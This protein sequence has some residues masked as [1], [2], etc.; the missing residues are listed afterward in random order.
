LESR[1]NFGRD[2]QGCILSEK[3]VIFQC[4]P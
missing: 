1:T 2:G 3:H 4:F